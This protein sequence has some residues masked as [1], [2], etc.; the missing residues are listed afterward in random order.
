MKEESEPK[1]LKIS[2][3]DEK[4]LLAI[5]EKKKQQERLARVQAWKQI[6]ALEDVKNENASEKGPE[7][8]EPAIANNSSNN[9]AAIVT[10]SSTKLPV[11][12]LKAGLSLFAGDEAKEKK[13]LTKLDDSLQNAKEGDRDL[14]LNVKQDEEQMQVEGARNPDASEEDELDDEDEIE[15][16]R[17]SLRLKEHGDEALHMEVEAQ[18]ADEQEEKK[19]FA[20]TIEA[21]KKEV[22]HNRNKVAAWKGITPSRTSKKTVAPELLL[23]ANGEDPLISYMRTISADFRKE[24]ESALAKAK[25]E[26]AQRGDV[27]IEEDEEDREAVIVKKKLIEAIDHRKQVYNEFRKDFYIPCPEINKMTPQEVSAFRKELDGIKIRGKNCPNPV[28]TFLQCGLKPKIVGVLE[29]YEYTKPTPIQAQAIPAVMSGLDVIGIA[30]TGSGKTLAYLLPMFRHI[31][32]QP[33]LDPSDGP[34]AIIMVPTRE[35]AVQ[36]HTECGKFTKVT[37][38]RSACVYGGAGVK[39]QIGDL[40]RGAEIVVCTPGPCDVPRIGRGG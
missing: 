29:R 17:T 22:T 11:P 25:E 28:K 30:K 32:D 40:K 19:P 14:L 9:N 26:A 4:L 35:L 15:R 31:M 2:E 20:M 6:N 33:P 21:P 8:Q 38:I 1:K 3:E 7:K 34:I 12:K 24:T 37:N 39:H 16:E 36:I 18:L 5:A 10:K 23:D 13:Q 27:H